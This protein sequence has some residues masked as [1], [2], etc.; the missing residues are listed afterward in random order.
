MEL[1]AAHVPGAVLPELVEAQLVRGRAH[2]TLTP[3]DRGLPGDGAPCSTGAV[4]LR[5]RA[6]T[7]PHEP[8][9]CSRA[10]RR[11]C[12]VF[13]YRRRRSRRGDEDSPSGCSECP[14]VALCPAA[15]SRAPGSGLMA[16]TPLQPAGLPNGP[17]GTV[18]GCATVGWGRLIPGPLSLLPH[19]MICLILVCLQLLLVAVLG[20]AVL[21]A[22]HSDQE[23]FYRLLPRVLPRAMYASLAYFT[24][25]TLR[26]VCDGLLPI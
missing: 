21:Y 5:C 16:R 20:S 22:Q 3:P 25:S 14:L 19:R 8:R 18:R 12:P 1:E 24:S 6:P 23:L 26:V 7:V 15:S 11:P 10:D 9:L 4:L 17:F 2:H 13:T